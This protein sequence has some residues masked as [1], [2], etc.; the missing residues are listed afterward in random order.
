MRT[1]RPG[2]RVRISGEVYRVERVNTCAAYLRPE[3]VE[4]REVAIGDRTFLAYSGGS[5]LAV[6]PQAFVERIP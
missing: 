3:Y 1:L 6:S 4:P 2:E 5:L